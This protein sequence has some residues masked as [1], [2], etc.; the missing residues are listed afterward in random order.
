[1][2]NVKSEIL[3]SVNQKSKGI[4]KLKIKMEIRGKTSTVYN[5]VLDGP[6]DKTG[7]DFAT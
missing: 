6:P 2:I 4:L 1:M 5:V 7:V 3:L